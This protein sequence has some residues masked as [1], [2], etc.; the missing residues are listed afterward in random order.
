LALS[1]ITTASPRAKAVFGAYWTL[2]K[3]SV[4]LRENVYGKTS[5][6]VSTDGTGNNGTVAKIG[7]TGIT[8]I[9]V[10]YNVTEAVKISIGAN[11]L[12]DHKAPT[13]PNIPN[14]SGG[15]RPADGA[16]VY[17]APLGFS[18]YGINGGYYYGRV[19]YTF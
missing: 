18:P 13:M 1:Y 14:G 8:D 12:F 15:V 2:N 3:F 4:N 17:D 7:T 6:I 11:N 10:G 9:D 16:N 19:T 5:E